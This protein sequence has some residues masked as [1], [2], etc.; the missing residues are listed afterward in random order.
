MEKFQ[1]SNKKKL[2]WQNSKL[3]FEWDFLLNFSKLNNKKK[4]ENDN[5]KNNKKKWK[6]K[7]KILKKEWKV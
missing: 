6:D 7:F 5:A 1:V 4:A 2:F 3:D